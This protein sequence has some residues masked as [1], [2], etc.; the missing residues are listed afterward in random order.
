MSGKI[1]YDFLKFNSSHFTPFIR[2][3]FVE[4]RQPKIFGFKDV[5]ERSERGIRKILTFLK[6]SIASKILAKITLKQL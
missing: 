6:R 1:P 3:I 2:L 4:K 5:M